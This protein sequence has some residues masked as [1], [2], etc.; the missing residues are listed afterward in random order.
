M[1]A[2]PYTVAFK[3]TSIAGCQM[4]L[5]GSDP[6][7]TGVA[8]ANGTTVS[9][10]VDK[11]GNANN[12]TAGGTGATYSSS[13]K[14]LLFG[15]LTA[16]PE[17]G[18]QRTFT[19]G[20]YYTTSYTANPTN[21]TCFVVFSMPVIGFGFMITSHSC[22]G[23]SLGT[24]LY[25]GTTAT[26]AGG[27][28]CT[29]WGVTAYTPLATSTIYIGELITSSGNQYG[30]VN[31]GTLAGPV[32]QS[33]S[34]GT[35]DIGGFNALNGYYF[36]GY[37]YE[38]LFYNSVLTT[39]QRQS[40]EGYLAWK[41]GVQAQ[42]PGYGIP[43]TALPTSIPAC[44]LWLDGADPAGT[45]TP[46]SAGTSIATWVDKSGQGQTITQATTSNQPTYTSGG[47]LTF[48]ATNQLYPLATTPF[49]TLFST[50]FSI[51]IVE[52]RATSSTTFMI[53]S[54][55]G[56]GGPLYVGY[57]GNTT[58]RFTTA[59]IADFD[60]S[61]PGYTGST[62]TEPTR[63]WVVDWFGASSNLRDIGLNG[64]LTPAT[65]A[66][67]QAPSISGEA[68]GGC[69][70]GGYLGKISEIIM[71]SNAVNST[72]RKQI[73]GYLATK[74]GLQSNLPS[75]HPYYLATSVHPYASAAPTAPNAL[76]ITRA[77]AVT[78]LVPTVKKATTAL[79]YYATFNPTS[80]AGCKLW[81]DAS[82][83]SSF[84]YTSGTNINQWKDKSGN[85]YNA[86]QFGTGST[87][88][89][90]NGLAGY[91]A[92][93]FG[94]TTANMSCSIPAGTFPAGV[95]GFVVAITNSGTI[96]R[97]VNNIPAPFDAAGTSL[98]VGNGSGF[99]VFSSSYNL[100]SSSLPI[101]YDFTVSTPMVFTQN[102]NGTA[103]TNYSIFSSAAAY[104]DTA[105]TITIGVRQD[106]GWVATG[107][108]SEI[109][110]YNS[111]LTTAQRQQIEGY[112][113][114]KWGLQAQLP[115]FTGSLLSSPTVLSG[116]QLW[117]DGADSSSS[118][119]TFSG[120]NITA[121][122]D[123]SGT[124]NNMT[125]TGTG[126]PYLTTTALGSQCIAFNGSNNFYNA[127]TVMSGSNN[128]YFFV[129]TAT[130]NTTGGLMYWG[131]NG[132][133]LSDWFYYNNPVG[134]FSFSSNQ[135]FTPSNALV[136]IT[137]NV[138]VLC[139]GYINGTSNGSQS[140][141]AMGSNQSL[142]I[143]SQH[144][145]YWRGTIQEVIIY[146]SAF[147]TTQRQQVEGYLAWKWGIQGNLPSNHPYYSA[148]PNHPYVSAAP[149]GA[150]QRAAAV[151]ALVPTPT[152]AFTAIVKV[153]NLPYYKVDSTSWST[154]WQPYLQALTSANSGATASLSTYSVTGSATNYTTTSY[155]ALAPNGLMYF[156][157][158]TGVFVLNPATNTATILGSASTSSYSGLVL[159]TN[160][161]LYGI[162]YG[163]GTVLVITPSATSPYGTVTTIGSG[164]DS[165]QGGCLGP[166]GTIYALPW[167]GSNILTINTS[168][169]TVTQVAI[170]P[171]CQTRGS[172]LG[173]DG[174]IY[175][176]PWSSS[177]I[178]KINTSTNTS[179]TISCD[180]GRYWG[181]CLAPNGL[182]YFSP[183]DSGQLI[184]LNVF[185][186]SVIT[187][188]SISNNASCCVVV[189]PNGK[190]YITGYNTGLYE[191][192]ITTN[193]IVSIGTVVGSSG[194][195]INLAPNGNLYI[196]GTSA[197]TGSYVS[198]SG[199]SQLPTLNYCLSAYTNKF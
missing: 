56:G 98:V 146:N 154:N 42:L 53:G 173:P 147:T 35:T 79:S 71:Y 51:F 118:S 136:A 45:G 135:F 14:A 76:G 68:I 153:G 160:G 191:Y 63:L 125:V 167:T 107:Y 168:T 39:A 78:A 88:Y 134:Y 170:S 111:V 188:V 85:G 95:T 175:G 31:G 38:I 130:T 129:A 169:N 142:M 181:C 106:K 87:T 28:I 184:S 80:I 177:A 138:G 105:T 52:K 74:W 165:Y 99:Q 55:S 166:N 185:T 33:Y 32:A 159:G 122:L 30:T 46:P 187:R 115:L 49:N 164:L 6:A 144:A 195:S 140:S 65:Q 64:Q 114:W 44:A 192:T 126:Y 186:N 50:S 59:S 8:P 178:L 197:T 103:Y 101:L 92:V 180:G 12:A 34:A 17:A 162:P 62:A 183:F 96:A 104:G 4:W 158:G 43:A 2:L 69:I 161:N 182:I 121:W 117:L 77:P 24:P 9:S 37:I 60:Y 66:F 128:T 152:K 20:N 156:I 36:N 196:P 149:T 22:S 119:M 67:S 7:G 48:S 171:S 13:Q 89:S 108:F 123:K 83:S 194:S 113:A 132:R 57:N 100:G 91:P 141:V 145:N 143:G 70:Y 54:T 16:T 139:T 75:G 109:L 86:T 81:L 3:P 72:Q 112:L 172:V 29:S 189:G 27:V 82:D 110:V 73:E 97:C 150:S 116:C 151:T 5:D 127:T 1:T 23:R 93:N 40:V 198:F 176:C 163:T 10:W 25:D 41:W 26:L 155:G 193:T 58:F 84:T 18:G 157:G 90:A 131:A 120:S 124:G 199:L 179:S 11:S 133:V 190:L 148:T 21:E 102:V 47:G 94:S 174:N 15:S 19:S 61:V 137:E